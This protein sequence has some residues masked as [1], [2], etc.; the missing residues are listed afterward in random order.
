MTRDAPL[1]NGLDELTRDAHV[2]VSRHAFEGFVVFG[3]CSRYGFLGVSKSV[4]RIGA[5]AWRGPIGTPVL[6][7]AASGHDGGMQSSRST[8]VECPWDAQ[9][10]THV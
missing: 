8:A 7:A 5:P 9:Q 2:L 4:S 3:L 10:H 6:P 1:N